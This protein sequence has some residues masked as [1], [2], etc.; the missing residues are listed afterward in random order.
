MA[1]ISDTFPVP[2]MQGP[3]QIIQFNRPPKPK[4]TSRRNLSKVPSSADGPRSNTEQGNK[5]DLVLTL[6]EVEVIDLTC[7]GRHPHS[8]RSNIAFVLA[9]YDD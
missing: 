8:R 5:E 6:D 2:Q 7:L 3:L 9:L 1:R 4:Q